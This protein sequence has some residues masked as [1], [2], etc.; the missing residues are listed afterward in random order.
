MFGSVLI[1]N[2]GEIACRIIRTCRRLGIRTIAVFSA[3]DARSRHVCLADES[4]Y[5]GPAEARLSYLDPERI[6]AAA[7]AHGADA[8]HPGYGFLSE[9]AELAELC[10]HHALHWIGPSARCIR[11]MGSKIE[12]KRLA[13]DAGVIGVPGYDGAE[14]SAEGL[15]RHAAAVGF[16]VL[17]KAS[18]GGGGKG[19]RRVDDAS[20]FHSSVE[21]AKREARAAFGDDRVLIE[22]YIARPRH[23]EVQLAGDKHSNLIHLFERECSIQRNYQKV[24]EEAPA[25]HL[26]A[27][28]RVKLFDA[29]I[30]LGHSVGYDSLGTVEF[31][32]DADAGENAEPYFLEMNTRLQVEHPV[33]EAITGL[34]MV[35]LQLRIAAGERLPLRQQDV[36]AN[37][38]AIEARVTAEEPQHDYRPASGTVQFYREPPA[39]EGV[40]VDSGITTGSQV[41]PYY[42]SLLAKVVGSGPDRDT[43]IRRL[44]AAL[45]GFLVLGVDTNREFL[46]TIIDHAAFQVGELTTRFIADAFPSGYAR[47]A[48]S[49]FAYAVAAIAMIF[50][51]IDCSEQ[52]GHGAWHQF[53]G[54]RVL[55]P[56]GYGNR[57]QCL[58]T[59]HDAIE[60]AVT[61][62]VTS[63]N[64]I[65]ID[66]SGQMFDLAIEWHD[67]RLTLQGDTRSD[68]A[69]FWADDSRISVVLRG[70]TDVFTV[71]TKVAALAAKSTAPSD[72]RPQVSAA[73]T[74]Q[75]VSVEVSLGQQV[76]AGQVLLVMEAMKLMHT[77][78]A[79]VAGVISR[80]N[81]EAG[82]LVTS[83][84]RLIEI[85]PARG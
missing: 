6:V 32:I 24:I 76:N 62:N 28:I 43:A 40:R 70:R 16:P 17:I 39:T 60:R 78:C 3:A 56:A 27:S 31:L 34:D 42:D 15:L 82:Q 11:A 35:E 37:G 2:R 75:I 41:S 81:C 73:L 83:G 54:F 68:R 77:M 45:D 71:T 79:P 64:R 84:A 46:R 74:G 36:I 29:A 9:R 7:T 23:L 57:V 22:K 33:T 85:E 10:A 8:V 80:I 13:R 5:I 49:E 1:A 52:N 18:A 69:I 50:R 55:T 4:H 59:S 58:V 12:A 44:L 67:D 48:P 61:I 20:S 30:R 25:P 53:L 19:M 63:R 66:V 26:P 21:L 14:Q 65:S 51:S 38:H 47:G 72:A